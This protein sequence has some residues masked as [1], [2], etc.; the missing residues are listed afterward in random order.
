MV[1]VYSTLEQN[2]SLMDQVNSVGLSSRVYQAIKQASARTG[3]D[4][5]YLVNKAA[6]ESS[7]DANATSTASSATGLYQFTQQTWLQMVKAHG[8]SYGLDDYADHIHVDNKGV[9]H[10]TDS[11]WRQA[12]LALRKDPQI[13]AEM[14]GELDK[15]NSTSL[16]QNVGGKIGSTELYLA[17]FLGAGGASDF[18]NEM[19]NN[20]GTVAANIL[21]EAAAANPTVFYQA[22]GT[23]KT[24]GQIYQHFAQKFEQK[25]TNVMLADQSN[26]MNSNRST[27][28]TL[29]NSQSVDMIA[30]SNAMTNSGF[31]TNGFR[32]YTATGEE[33]TGSASLFATMILAQSDLK[34][35]SS[36]SYDESSYSERHHKNDSFSWQATA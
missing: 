10:A 32:P 2:N 28:M 36:Q 15:D 20:P 22:N 13:S 35:K 30:S 6:Q 17:H 12:I 7:F 9:A 25:S 24:L 4:F 23:P 14:A 33:A 1:N 29:P 19:K 8:K 26:V 11:S 3:V 31:A 18:L 16:K 27:K 5:T 21:P 34:E